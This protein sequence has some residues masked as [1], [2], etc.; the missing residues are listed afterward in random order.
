MIIVQH[1]KLL[2]D[3]QPYLSCIGDAEAARAYQASQKARNV[4]LNV[5]KGSNGTGFRAVHTA[6]LI[7]TCPYCGEHHAGKGSHKSASECMRMAEG[8]LYGED[9]ETGELLDIR[10]GCGAVYRKLNG[11]SARQANI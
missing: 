1:G 7:L 4:K 9:K 2:K 10:C 11:Q 6:V 3:G 5:T 8:K